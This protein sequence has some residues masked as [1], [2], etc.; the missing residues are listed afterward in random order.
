[1]AYEPAITYILFIIIQTHDVLYV[2]LIYSLHTFEFVYI[3]YKNDK[4]KIP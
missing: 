1:M 2:L 4:N 3:K